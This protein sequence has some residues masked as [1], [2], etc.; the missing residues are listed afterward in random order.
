MKKKII[1]MSLMTVALICVLA[2]S[3]F[4]TEF[5]VTTA[6]EFNNAYSQAQDGDTIVIKADISAQFNFGKTITY[7]LDGGVKWSANGGYGTN[8]CDATGKTV[9]VFAR[10]GDGVFYPASGMW[11]NN[12]D[13]NTTNDLSS[14]TFSLGSLDN[15]KL[16][17]DCSVFSA[18]NSRMFYNATLKEFNLLPGAVVTNLNVIG[19]G[20][21]YIHAATVNMYEGAEIYGNKMTNYTAIVCADNFNIYGGKIYG[22]YF[23]CYGLSQSSNTKMFGGEI[24]GNYV[25]GV[26]NNG[27]PSALLNGKAGSTNGYFE[28]YNGS[29]KNNVLLT[30]VP[31]RQSILCASGGSHITAGVHSDNYETADWGDEPTKVGNI[32]VS[33]YDVANAS[34]ST[35]QAYYTTADYAIVFKNS[36]SSAIAAYMVKSDGSVLKSYNGSTE[37]VVPESLSGWTTKAN[38]CETTTVDTT[39]SGTY[40]VAI[41]HAADADDFD[42]T[43]ALSCANCGKELAP[44]QD[45]HVMVEDWT[46]ANG[47]FKT[48]LYTCDCTN[49]GCTVVDVSEVKEPVFYWVG[50]SARE[51][52]DDRAFGQQYIINKTVLEDYSAYLNE[53]GVKFSYGVVAAGSSSNGDPLEVVNDTVKEKTGAVAIDFSALSYDA[54]FMNISGI[55]AESVAEKALVCCAYIQI[56]DTVSYLD[57]GAQTQ[58]VTLRTFNDIVALIPKSDDE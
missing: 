40:Y 51:F 43:T 54:F 11:F 24:F 13:S 45:S 37:I 20:S 47:V 38:Y 26:A 18:G 2:V 22:N 7:I 52:G 6:D 46:Y 21:R 44:K 30:N 23:G 42:C 41:A 28:I 53:K 27:V 19:S 55:P 4:A 36:D 12:T 35:I 56:G 39:K 32:Y 15:S 25:T 50:F 17:L 5:T 58:V 48:G 14:T 10:N 34:E 57:N 3:A 49:E 8:M 1:L 31:D 33:S 16:T 9:R 29:I